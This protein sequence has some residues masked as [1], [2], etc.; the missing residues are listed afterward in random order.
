[1]SSLAVWP[2]GVLALSARSGRPSEKSHPQRAAPAFRLPERP[3]GRRITGFCLPFCPQSAPLCRQSAPFCPQS[4]PL[5][6]HNAPPCRQNGPFRPQRG[7]LC[8]ERGTF[9]PQR[10]A[11]C[12]HN[13]PLCPAPARRQ[14]QKTEHHRPPV[15]GRIRGAVRDGRA[16]PFSVSHAR[17]RTLN[18]PPPHTHTPFRSS[19]KIL[20]ADL[21]F[22]L[23]P[24]PRSR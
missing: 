24:R 22:W 6:R 23:V 9:C 20:A 19:A 5:C 18:P 8:P 10:G 1:L 2:F 17:F 3:E 14:P 7:P 15:S 21:H 11:V 4:A 12:P 13:A 16:V